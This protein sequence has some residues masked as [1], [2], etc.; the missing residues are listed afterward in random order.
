VTANSST[1]PRSG[2]LTIAG[3]LISVTQAGLVA[4]TGGQVQWV[5]ATAGTGSATASSVKADR[6][7]NVI[8]AGHFLGTVDFGGGPIVGNSVLQ[9]DIFVAKY[10]AQGGFLWAKKLG[11]AVDSDIVES[12]AI[13]SADN[14]IVTGYIVGTVDFG[15]MTLT[16]NGWGDVFVA[17]YSPQGGLLWAKNFGG[18]GF[19]WGRAVAVDGNDNVLLAATFTFTA[20]WG[21]ISLTCASGNA[22]AL[23]KL[24]SAG[25]V[26]WAKAWGEPG[27]AYSHIGPHG[28]AVDR[29]GDVVVTGE[30]DVPTDLGGGTIN[31]GVDAT[32]FVAK[33]SGFD[34]S[35]RWAKATGGTG[36]NRG[37]GVATDPTTGNVIVTGTVQGTVD[38]GGSPITATNPSL[39]LAGYDVSGR[40]TWAKAFP[41]GDSSTRSYG[42][43]V[44]VDATG[45]IAVAGCVAGGVNL[46]GIY[47]FGGSVGNSFVATWTPQEST[48]PVCR[49][50]KS[51]GGGGLAEG[52]GVAFDSLGHVL[53]AGGFEGTKDFGGISATAPPGAMAGF[54]AQ[55]TK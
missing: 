30:F 29:S 1:S 37:Y 7:G 15:G 22:M 3:Q 34:G 13:D 50:A 31:P 39:F 44:S 45:T 18:I 51:L 23:V 24:S 32:I 49:W 47:V 42:Y 52:Y 10:T 53:A 2:T 55:Y 12:V 25:A 26:L 5:R 6:S 4:T 54:V 46:G 41:N 17:K 33:Y 21:G 11:S 27:T 28:L 9:W 14:I 16:S 43:A 36:S 48:P 8:V 40:F 38:F 35:Y 20:N 19:D